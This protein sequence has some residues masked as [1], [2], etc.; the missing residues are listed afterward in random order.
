MSMAFETVYRK[1]LI[2]KLGSI[3]TKCELHMIHVPINDV[4]LNVKIGNK[5]GPDIH[6]NIGICQ[7]DCLSAPLFILYLAFAVKPLPPVI[8]ALD[9][10]KPLWSAL[11]WIMDRDVHIITIDPKHAY[12][13]LFLRSDESKINQVERDIYYVGHRSFVA[14]RRLACK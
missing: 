14:H 3:L 9:H 4:I 1:E 10:H 6:T 8:S 5:T 2:N 13:I 11:D 7:G 12:D